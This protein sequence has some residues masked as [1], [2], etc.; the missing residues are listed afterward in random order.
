ML[1]ACLLSAAEPRT[2]RPADVAVAQLER[3]RMIIRQ[4]IGLATLGPWKICQLIGMSRSAL[5]RLFEP[6]GGVAHNI[7]T[8]RMRVAHTMLADPATAGQSIGVIAE[9]VGMF[10]ASTVSRIFRREFGYAPS[11]AR[12]GVNLAPPGRS[13][14]AAGFATLLRSAAA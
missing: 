11:E 6:Q 13:Q 8:E 7:Q 2:V 1:T 9:K 10:D 14:A 12:A 3:A 5:H 4:N